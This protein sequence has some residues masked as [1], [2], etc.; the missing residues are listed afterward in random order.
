M[1]C[2]EM[3]NI[4]IEQ[5]PMYLDK[6]VK[7]IK[8]AKMTNVTSTIKV[9]EL[10]PEELEELEIALKAAR[11]IIGIKELVKEICD[12]PP[13]RAKEVLCNMAK[14]A[15]ER[16]SHKSGWEKYILDSIQK[17]M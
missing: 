11:P 16:S 9:E 17:N 2:L 12:L 6:M 5:R 3:D 4:N 14:K 7:I 10:K 8:V 1:T 13:E 15:E